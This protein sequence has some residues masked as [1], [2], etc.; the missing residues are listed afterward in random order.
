MVL[1][2]DKGRQT[3]AD[4]IRRQR[5]MILM[6]SEVVFVDVGGNTEGGTGECY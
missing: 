4:T 6:T 3:S 5:H 1:V 2:I